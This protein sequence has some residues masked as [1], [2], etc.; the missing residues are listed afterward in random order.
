MLDAVGA[1]TDASVCP[2]VVVAWQGRGQLPLP[3][4]P[5]EVS[6][7]CEDGTTQTCAGDSDNGAVPLPLLPLGYHRGVARVAKQRF[8]FTIIAAPS[9]CYGTSATAERRWG[10]F[11]PL[12]AVGRRDGSGCGDL[13]DLESLAK[14]TGSRGGSFVG[15]LPILASFVTDPVEVSPYAPVSRLFWN[16]LYLDLE[17][18]PGFSDLEAPLRE[19]IGRGFRALRLGDH[20][21]FVRLHQAIRPVLSELAALAPPV[22]EQ[23]AGADEIADFAAFLSERDGSDPIVNAFCQREMQRQLAAVASRC[24]DRGVDLYLDLPVGSHPLGYDVQR[25]PHS[26]ADGICCGAP[27]DLLFAGGQNWGFP[28]LH[29]GGIRDD[30]YSLVRKIIANHCRFAGVLR[31]D[32]VMWLHRIYWIPD[33][34]AATDGVYVHNH[35]DELWA[36]L[37]LESH[38]HSTI[39]IG[40]DLGTVPAAVQSQMQT[41]GAI[42]MHLAQF[43]LGGDPHDAIAEPPPQTIASLGSHDTPTFASFWTGADVELAE[44]IGHVSTS[45]AQTIRDEREQTKRATLQTLRDRELL[46]EDDPAVDD[47]LRAMLAVIASSP[48]HFAVVSLEDLWGETRPQNVPGTTTEI[49]NWT[50]R[51]QLTV[52]ELIE[53]NEVRRILED[54]NARRLAAPEPSSLRAAAKRTPSELEKQVTAV[55]NDDLY[56]FGEGS[57]LQ[58]FDFLG[59]HPRTAL[60]AKGTRF[61][62]WAPNATRVSVTGD[63]NDWDASVHPLQARQVSGIWEGFV[64]GAL[65]GDR[66]KFAVR[67][68]EGAVLEKADPVAF[69]TEVPPKTA[70]VICDL[71]Y[72][73]NDE[74][75]MRERSAKSD[76]KAPISIY[77]LHLGSFMR[78]P[79]EGNRS[80]QYR[81]AAERIA[82]HVDNLGFTHVELMPIMEH[83][84]YGSW[85]YQTT[86]YFA[87]TS[88]YG[89]PQDLMAL[90][91]HLHQRG[92]GVILDWV[93]SHFPNDA[94]G[95][96]EFDGTHLFEHADP[97]LGFHPDWRSCI[98]NYGRNEVRSFLISSALFWLHNYHIDGIR[99]DA[100]AS[101]LYRDYS[102]NEGEWIPNEHGGRENLEAVS[103]L[104]Q[105][106]E[107]IYSRFPG[108]QTYAEEST[109]WPGVSRPT[110]AGGL[111]FGY[112]WDMGW[113]HDT[114]R[115][116]ARDPIHRRHHQ[117]ELSFRMMY[118]F[119]ENYVLSLSHD[120]VVHGKGSLLERMPGDDSQKRANLRLLYGNMFANPGKK[121]LFMGQEF[122]QPREWSHEASLDWHLADAPGG[123]GTLRWVRDLN[124]VYRREPA[125]HQLDCDPTGFEWIDYADAERSIYAFARRAEDGSA[126]V[127]VANYTPTP[128]PGY[129]IGVPRSGK[130]SVIANS[131]AET[132]GGSGS[133]I[134]N[135]I[136]AD[137][138]EWHGRPASIVLDL[139]PLAIVMLK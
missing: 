116:F 2:P 32:H 54:V 24:R 55:S 42:G 9:R 72:K 59:A 106:N 34:F 53:S 138:I 58:V 23:T 3:A 60:G 28:P 4:G 83:P 78:V 63:W 105:L 133:P 131:D 62:V 135:E 65:V 123:G 8:A 117:A 85:G 5:Y 27:P 48:A 10:T 136:E 99:V 19:T 39:V 86:G 100:V 87:P 97:R 104:R 88:R 51:S 44:D 17:A 26:F 33:G 91:D 21:D 114:L 20:V 122:A 125:L 1:E 127:V 71:A 120:E 31:V 47:V 50:R 113:M 25:Y 36:I 6:V 118:A 112:K 121:L 73:W 95:L 18:V 76:R 80:L 70:S 16:P 89:S 139:P 77:E 7:A 93:P 96:A 11:A 137:E 14:Y 110:Y 101:M 102:R 30:G 52:D 126:I 37:C 94:H 109:A 92:I 79:E 12:Y 69:A 111:G 43:G 129:R 40:E 41:R 75:W 66:Y 98:F 68:R 103:F 84:F 119:S 74:S 22:P 128:A 13:R 56:L 108:V 132:Y 115:Y 38:R 49:A 64:P 67:S 130:W 82:E 90:V 15:T 61:C 124:A 46:V 134:A 45:A 29:P 57:H 107:A 35:A 81:E